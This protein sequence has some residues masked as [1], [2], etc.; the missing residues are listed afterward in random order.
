MMPMQDCPCYTRK[1]GADTLLVGSY[2]HVVRKPN[3]AELRWESAPSRIWSRYDRGSEI[4]PTIE[5][6]RTVS[7]NNAFKVQ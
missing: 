5:S 1:R 6:R 2:V 4:H 7:A 3:E